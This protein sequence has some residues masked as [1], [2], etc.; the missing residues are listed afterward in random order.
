[1]RHLSP[2]LADLAS[3]CLSP[4]PALR[5]TMKEVCT[6]LSEVSLEPRGLTQPQVHLHHG[7]PPPGAGGGGGQAGGQ[8]ELTR[9]PTWPRSATAAAVEAMKRSNRT[10][11][12]LFEIFPPKVCGRRCRGG[13]GG[14]G[15]VVQE[16]LVCLGSG[17]Q[18]LSCDVA[19]SHLP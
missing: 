11:D 5:P 12:L 8:G 3:A 1:M 9:N 18:L 15:A 19:L 14:L 7:A 6:E 13:G 10:E 17:H 2:A 16:W 4:D